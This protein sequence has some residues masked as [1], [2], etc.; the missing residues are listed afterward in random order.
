M[1]L[2][3]LGLSKQDFPRSHSV[4]QAG[5]ELTR[6]P[7]SASLSLLELKVRTTTPGS[8]KTHNV[9]M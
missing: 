6:D 8:M 2:F 4:D 9:T 7:A 3:I 1:Y 5:L